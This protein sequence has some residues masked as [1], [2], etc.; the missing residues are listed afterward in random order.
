LERPTHSNTSWE[1]A[2]FE[3][4]G[5]RWADV[6]ERNGG[7]S[8][9]N[10]CKYGYDI[11]GRT[12]RLSLLRAPTWPDANADQG[13]HEFTY[14]LLPHAG[15]WREAHVVRRAMELNH[16]AAAVAAT[17]HAGAL[18]AER[19]WVRFDSE[20]VVLDTIKASEDGSGTILRFYES[21]GGRETVRLKWMQSIASASLVN[22]LEDEVAALEFADDGS[23]ELSF[24]PFEIKTVKL[25]S[26]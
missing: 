1:R 22:L 4:C 25:V 6:S 15:D 12:M 3:V 13:D 2:Q 5:H 7:V 11:K 24:G 16:P 14:S 23:L 17:A 10:D 8:L 9:L 21:S 19:A 18:P 26:P 20:H